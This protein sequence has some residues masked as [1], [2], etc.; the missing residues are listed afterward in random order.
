MS[1]VDVLFLHPSTCV[2]V[3][4]GEAIR[5]VAMP[6]GMLALADLLE[7]NGYSTRIIHTG[8]K[9]MINPSYSVEDVVKKF[10]PMLVGIDLHW[11]CHS[12]DAIKLAD[13]V[14]QCSDAKVVLGGMTASFFAEEILGS[15]D[16]VDYVIVGDAELPMLELTRV[17]ASRSDVGDVPNLVYRK[18]S[19]VKRSRKAYL[20]SGVDLDK[21][22]FSNL[23]LLEDWDLYIRL[24]HEND[25]L[26]PKLKT[27][28]WLM[29]GRGCSVNCSYCG[30]AKLA[31][32]K[33]FGRQQ[34]IFRS[35]EKVAEDLRVFEELGISCAYIDFD[36]Y[37]ER[38]FYYRLFELV[39]KERID[40]SSQ[41]LVWSLTDRNFVQNLKR[42]FNPLYT[43]LTISPET[44]SDTVRFQ[45]KGFYYDNQSFLKWLEMLEE[46]MVPAELYFAA[47]LSGETVEE[48]KKTMKLG[49]KT[50]RTYRNV[51]AASCSPLFLE[52]CSPRFLVPKKYGIRLK[53]KR[54]I[55]FY[56]TYKCFAEGT[57]PA[58]RLGYDT[59]H[60]NESQIIELSSKFND[61]VNSIIEKENLAPKKA[62]EG[63]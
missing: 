25:V 18:D 3:S 5:Y 17:L 33:I 35:P 61:M 11:Y 60:L 34:P 15:F 30:G 43:T 62:I 9:R 52:P 56:E 7:R 2:L 12:Y 54:F 29:I 46:E 51:V 6:M 27:Q 57:A 36:P 16:C 1:D 28:G 14:K 31:H 38:K 59:E 24:I 40:I 49:E 58:S 53:F 39:R 10:R 20:A 21:L 37:V 55:D 32:A 44:G 4:G 63:W 26:S 50:I 19:T 47:G 48:F 22:T 41:F 23:K 13:S 8:I 45:N 42:A